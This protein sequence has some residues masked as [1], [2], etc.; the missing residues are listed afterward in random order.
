MKTYNVEEVR[1]AIL[2]YRKENDMNITQFKDHTWVA[3]QTQYAIMNGEVSYIHPKTIKKL[4]DSGV[5]K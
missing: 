3:R 4:S 5:L 2:Q 1:L